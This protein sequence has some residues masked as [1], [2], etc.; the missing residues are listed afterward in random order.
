MITSEAKAVGIHE[1]E[2]ISSSEPSE[3]G[4]RGEPPYED[5]GAD[6]DPHPA[7]SEAPDHD[8]AGQERSERGQGRSD[9]PSTCV[10]GA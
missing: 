5:A 4:V 2:R 9:G 3:K 1:E 7:G 10:A 6:A 8:D